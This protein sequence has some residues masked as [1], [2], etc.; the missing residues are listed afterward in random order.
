MSKANCFHFV[1]VLVSPCH[2]LPHYI[3]EKKI[4][5]TLFLISWMTRPRDRKGFFFLK[6]ATPKIGPSNLE[7]GPETLESFL[8]RESR[9]FENISKEEKYTSPCVMASE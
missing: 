4:V 2:T 3:K 1:R 6:T 8:E 7:I 5:F 9:D